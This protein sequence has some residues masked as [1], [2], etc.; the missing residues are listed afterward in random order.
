MFNLP[1]VTPNQAPKIAERWEKGRLRRASKVKRVT[2]E[3]GTQMRPGNVFKYLNHY[4]NYPGIKDWLKRVEAC[5]PIVDDSG[6]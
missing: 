6:P 4:W 5:L 1:R 3:T 2:V